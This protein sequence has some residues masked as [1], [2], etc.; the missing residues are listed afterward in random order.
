MNGRWSPRA[1]SDMAGNGAPENEY[2]YLQTTPAN[3]NQGPEGTRQGGQAEQL[4]CPC[5]G[6]H[7]I[8]E[9]SNG[10]SWSHNVETCRLVNLALSDMEI[11]LDQSIR[12]DI[13]RSS[14]PLKGYYSPADPYTIHVSE[15]AYS[16]YP[17]YVIFHETK[18]LV[19][20]IM[21]G[22]SEED[23]PDPFARSLCVKHGFGVPPP[24]PNFAPAQFSYAPWPRSV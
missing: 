14:G 6:S 1:A 3:S 19:D 18:H 22:W 8:H 24:H 17:E 5:C 13:Y 2:N 4:F 12:V 11:S 20:C 16:R 7:V 9:T 10:L 15:E 21:K 23:T